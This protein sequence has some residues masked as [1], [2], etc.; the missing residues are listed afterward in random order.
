MNIV[1]R[2][3]FLHDTKNFDSLFWEND[4]VHFLDTYF[5]NFLK[6]CLHESSVNGDILT[7]HFHPSLAYI[8]NNK[9]NPDFFVPTTLYSFY[10]NFNSF[11]SATF[12][13]GTK[14]P[15]ALDKALWWT[16]FN[17]LNSPLNAKSCYKYDF[18]DLYLEFRSNPFQTY[19]S[20]TYFINDIPDLAFRLSD[21][22]YKTYGDFILANI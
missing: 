21:F 2:E 19:E 17:N 18:D 15:L 14:F 9:L 1:K 3:N 20:Q 6:Q 22:C 12:D 5:C 16:L 4:L 11:F 13:F 7:P 10:N 8:K